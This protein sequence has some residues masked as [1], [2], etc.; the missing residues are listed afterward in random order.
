MKLIRGFILST[1]IGDSQFEGS[2]F[3]QKNI[4]K[5]SLIWSG[6]YERNIRRFIKE[7]EARLW[8]AEMPNDSVRREWLQ[9]PIVFD[10]GLELDMDHGRFINHSSGP[11]IVYPLIEDNRCF[12]LRY[13]M[14]GEESFENY[15]N[16]E[17]KVSPTSVLVL[18]WLTNIYAE[19]DI[20][21]SNRDE[22]RI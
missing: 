5:R 11:N 21:K 16:Y 6:V 7:K 14:K 20:D 17:P 10:G 9:F 13:I 4:I 1:K 8:L 18:S 19:C 12:A 2:I 15:N 22:N 3:A